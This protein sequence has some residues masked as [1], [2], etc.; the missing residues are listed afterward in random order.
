MSRK[1]DRL[2]GKIISA[3]F[4]VLVFAFITLLVYTK[5][6]PAKYLAIV[7]GVLILLVLVVYLL[8]RKLRH[9]VPFV[10]GIVLMLLVVVFM[11]FG[12]LYIYKTV[13]TIDNITGVNTEV[14]QIGVYVLSDDA[15]ESINDAAG[16]TFGILSSLDRESTDDTVSQLNAELPNSIQ[17]QEYMTLTELADAILRGQTGAIILNQAYL[18]VLDEMDGYDN[19]SSLV[20]EITTKHVETVIERT[21]PQRVVDTGNSNTNDMVFTLYISGIDTRG[22]MTAKSRSDVNIIATVNTKTKQILLVSTPRDYYVPLSISNGAPDKL[23]HAGIYGINVCMDTLGMLYEEDI[24]YYF[25]LNFGGFVN[26]IDALGGI[27]I[28]SDYDF[29]SKNITGYHFNQGENFVNGEQALVFARERYAFTEGDRQ[30][31]RNQMAVIEGVIKKALSP[32]LLRNYTSVLSGIEGSF[33]TNVP[34]DMIASLVRDQL[35]DGGNW[36][37]VSYSVDGTGDTQKPYSMSQKAYVM[38]PDYTTVDKAKA[39]MD[40]VRNGEV[41][42]Q[43]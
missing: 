42:S 34:Y 36:N 2:P 21:E 31:G 40:Q 8:V 41:I 7:C 20:R 32:D 14:A 19:F 18:D 37:V 43:E 23:T 25:R 1:K 38:V 3:V 11:G 9:K 28:N 17:T 35:N 13:N 10:I 22:A 4:F 24:N 6:L 15:A 12:S 26:I 5:L 39:L 29:D 33:E 16:Y 30:R 27:T